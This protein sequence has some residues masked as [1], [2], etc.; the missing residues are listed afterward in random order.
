MDLQTTTSAI[1]QARLK[2][3]QS[4]HILDTP[5]EK[6]FDEIVQLASYICGTPISLIS[7]IDE[8]RQWFKAN[9]GLDAKETP[10]E[11]A[12]CAHAIEQEEV[13]V[14]NDATQDQR[15]AN[16]PMVTGDPNIR[17]YAGAP[18]IGKNNHKLGTLC[19]IDS[20]PRNLSNEQKDALKI[21]A[22]QVVLQFELRVRNRA[23]HKNITELN[24]E[25]AKVDRLNL[26]LKNAI[27]AK[28]RAFSII[29]HDLRSPLTRISSMVS[30]ID[31][32][33]NPD[34]LSSIKKLVPALR[35]SLGA[36]IDMLDSLVAWGSTSY[37]REKVKL[38]PVLLNKVFE[39]VVSDVQA[40]F[41]DK[42][43]TLLVDI[44]E[45]EIWLVASEQ[46]L[47]IVLRNLVNNANKFTQKGTVTLSATKV[48]SEWQLCVTDTGIGMNEEQLSQLLNWG[49]R[50]TTEGTASEKG[51]GLG[52]LMSRDLVHSM[53]GELSISSQQ[54]KGTRVC[55]SLNEASVNK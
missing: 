34:F 26:T 19:V 42:G 46:P 8:E 33:S 23:L 49:D 2:V 44:Q 16:K 18:L 30:L 22:K 1:E 24:E 13:M 31:T 5:A 29:G 51:S 37:S 14:V 12:F 54:Y 43:N 40:A 9:K 55:F 52:L 21:L 41:E 3:L 25:R 53:Q 47:R 4:Y 6:D 10:R 50:Y 20:K 28:D 36:T 7:L 11:E 39:N 15:F 27:K 38:R 45:K 48:E 35:Q 32:T 17:F